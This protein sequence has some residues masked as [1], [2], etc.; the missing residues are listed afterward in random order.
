VRCWLFAL[1]LCL[2]GFPALAENISV[3]PGGNGG[4]A[5]SI[6]VGTTTISGGTNGNIE[7]NNAGV[8]G[9]KAVTGTG[10]VVLA[11][12]PTLVTP[13]IGTPSAG[14]ATNL[15][16]MAAGLT[17]GNV[18]TNAN[19]TG[20]ITSLGNATS[21][22]SQTG[23]GTKFVVDTS[24]ALAGTPTTPTATAGTNTTQIA[25]TAYVTTAVANAIAGVN[26]A[27]AVQA[28]TTAAADT[29]GLTYNNGAAGI[30]AT[31]TGSVNTA[32][33]VD[34]FTFTTLNQRVL[35]KNDT[36]SPSGA[37]NGI[38]YVTQLQTS[39]LPPILTRALDYDAPSDINNT[40]AIPVVNGTVN[41][42]T[43]WLLTSTVATVGTDPLT[44]TKFSI[45]PSTL[46]A[47]ATSG[48]ANDLSAGT[49]AAAR[50]GA[51]T[52]NGALKGNGSGVVSQAACAD[53]SN[54]AASCSTDATNASNISSGT[55]AVARGGTNATTVAGAQAGFNIGL[56]SFRADGVNFNA[57][58]GTDIFHVTP[59]KPTGS[60]GWVS[61]TVR[62]FNC[63]AAI[64]TAH[65]GVFDGVG[66]TGTTVVSN[67]AGSATAQGPNVTASLQTLVQTIGPMWLNATDFYLNLITQQGSAVTCSVVIQLQTL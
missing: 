5:T 32:F 15:T 63:T 28:A 12:S 37:F 10:S 16:G 51:G 40:G 48:S 4:A 21:I 66:A 36:Q 23:T 59:A 31:F 61:V 1:A 6:T 52:I 26:P 57:A 13:N 58:N 46:A 18:T 14:V 8:L 65:F 19:L 11:T 49:V 33:T 3:T 30:G 24:P 64:T 53:L 55:L 54:A 50:G 45:N 43:S 62:I 41:G 9:E 29:S 27:V 67:T 20:P 44:F 39:I 34:G 42:T 17:A 22:A 47:I 7:F 60:L 25:S 2:V 38:Y 35:I 56:I